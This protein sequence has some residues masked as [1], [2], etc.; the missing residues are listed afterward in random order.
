MDERDAAGLTPLHEA[1][2]CPSPD[3]ACRALLFRMTGSLAA[4]W[5]RGGGTAGTSSLGVRLHISVLGGAAGVVL[6]G[7][8]PGDPDLITLRGLRAIQSADVLMYD[9]LVHP[10]LLEY[11]RR[12]VELVDV[13]KQGPREEAGAKGWGSTQGSSAAPRPTAS[14]STACHCLRS[15]SRWV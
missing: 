14:G 7:A 15:V 1:A 3:A 11:A 9:K 2:C 4:D 8:G 13:G 5:V 12:D 6:V 10:S